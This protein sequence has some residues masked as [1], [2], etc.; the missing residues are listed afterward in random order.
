MPSFHLTQYF[1]VA[2]VYAGIYDNNVVP[3]LLAS[4]LTASNIRGH[5]HWVSDMVAGAAIGIGIGSLILNQYEDRKYSADG[6]VLLPVVS[7]SGLGFSFSM[8]F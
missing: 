7:S 8:E 2:R 3:Y 4:A 6:G 1:A 5:H